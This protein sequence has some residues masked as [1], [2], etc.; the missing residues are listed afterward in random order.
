MD[1][2]TTTGLASNRDILAGLALSTGFAWN[3]QGVLI[4]LDLALNIDLASNMG[5]ASNNHV[6]IISNENVL[7]DC[8]SIL[9]D[10]LGRSSI[11]L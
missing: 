2:S 10:F 8:L 1:Q 7:N 6:S 9:A 5:L 11:L 3:D 4:A